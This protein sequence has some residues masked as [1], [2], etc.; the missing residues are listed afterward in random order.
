MNYLKKYFSS[1]EPQGTT[2]RDKKIFYLPMATFKGILERFI[3]SICL[4]NNILP[5]LTVFGA[6]KIGTRLSSKDNI[7]AND[8]FLIGNLCSILISVTYY[9]IF[10][11]I[12]PP[13]S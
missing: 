6:L 2:I 11:L 4:L 8:Y 5:I 3:I 12:Y 9:L 1:D 7:I 10:S 13:H